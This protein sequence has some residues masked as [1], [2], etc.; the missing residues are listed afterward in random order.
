M[1]DTAPQIPPDLYDHL[2]NAQNVEQVTGAIRTFLDDGDTETF[3]YAVAL[4]LA[5]ARSRGVPI[6]KVLEVLTNLGES[7]EGRVPA[8]SRLQASIFRGILRVF[9]GEVSLEDRVR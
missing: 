3:E 8:A 1:R 4:Y 2:T 7:I 5:S 6:A 9:F